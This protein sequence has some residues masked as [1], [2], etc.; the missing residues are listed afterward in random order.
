MKIL[1]SII[2][3]LL[4]SFNSQA[5]SDQARLLENAKSYIQS[6]RYGE[7]IELLNRF[8]AANPQSYEG[9][10]LR[11]ICHE[12]RGNYEQAVYDYRT[13]I[14]ISP[15]NKE[16]SENLA[17]AEGDWHRLLYNLIEGYKRE[18][19]INPSDPK[20]YLE[21]GKCYKNLGEW[22]EA[23][24]W[25]DLYLEKEEASSD[26]MLRYTEILA[27]NNHIL[28]GESYLKNYV[29]KYPDD[30]RL[31]SRYGYFLYWLGKTR[32][33][34]TAF[35]QA[36]KLRPFFKEALDGLDLLKGKKGL[37]TINDTNYFPEKGKKEKVYLIDKYLKLL[38]KNPDKDELRFNLINEFMKYNRIEEAYQQ[39][40]ILKPKYENQQRF[41][42]LYS[43]ILDKRN[44][45]IEREITALKSSVK[46]NPDDKK[47]L[48]K[49]AEL[50]SYRDHLSEAISLLKNYLLLNDD[51]EVQFLLAK[52]YMWNSDLCQSKEQLEYLEQKKYPDPQVA[53]LLA[54]IYL[55]LGI[56][57]Q[58]S[59]FLFEK[60][61]NENPDN[62][63]AIRGLIEAEL[64]LEK[65]KEAEKILSEN[66]HLFSTSEVLQIKTRIGELEGKKKLSDEYKILE[67]ARLLAGNKNYQLAIRR[68][69][70]FIN[71]QSQ[72]IQAK[73]ELADIYAAVLQFEKANE[74]LTEILN[75][76]YDLNFDKR[77]AKNIFWSKDYKTAIK[78]FKRLS[79]KFPDDVEIKIFLADSYLFNGDSDKAR[80]IYYSLLNQ[81]PESY[82][83]NQ[84]LVWLG[85][86]PPSEGFNYSVQLIPSANH[87]SDN[88]NI[89]YSGQSFLFRTAFTKNFAV[90]GAIH[91]GGLSSLSEE[92]TLYMVKGMLYL[93]LTDLMKTEA[94]FGQLFFNTK[95]KQFFGE[96]ILTISKLKN[97]SLNVSYKRS[98]A[99]IE[100]YSPSLVKK[101][102]YLNSSKINFLFN[103]G[104]NF[105]I[106]STYQLIFPE[107][108][109][110]GH[111]FS[112]K[113]GNNFVRNFSAG[114]EF[115]YL[116]FKE[117]S[118]LYWSPGNFISHS[119][120]SEW[121]ILK[122]SD[123]NLKCGGKIGLIPE[124]KFIL[125]EA[126][127]DFNYS[128]SHN[129]SFNAYVS[130]GKTYRKEA[131]GYTSF[132][133]I[134]S[135]TFSL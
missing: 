87:F 103:P 28:K 10:N 33:A 85:D 78:E 82:I 105:I 111:Q 34:E 92:R 126:F 131:G 5:Q 119:L 109:N 65:F 36:L 101:R 83:L 115:Y 107:D 19:A 125:S 106:S 14:K 4:L 48:M 68:Y 29:G 7:A 129:L 70:D 114:Y 93:S 104:F 9:F 79:L 56:E 57:I 116:N 88:Q 96:L 15:N 102:M 74:I 62:R 98:D 40:E 117:Q 3:F 58:K 23:E 45:I 31:W 61:L 25:Y 84:R 112:A 16:V 128:L 2:L 8:V 46:N 94:S 130:G 49:L 39:I 13:A 32:L 76:S 80:P 121:Q 73:S 20:N 43:K 44:E 38:N 35:E 77:R 67:E 91:R 134:S 59:E 89:T 110:E 63:D 21:I 118:D 11:G 26:E 124:N 53:L 97:F 60:Y 12:K 24:I 120:W 71:L 55:W 123:A 50:L 100:L 52:Y 17:R 135:L 64:I 95:E 47:S 86:N 54:K 30:H 41:Q 132:S 37:Y 27:K 6:E 113:I 122:L 133:L 22:N 72:N 69:L 75:K 99:S 127:M 66:E 81:A 42:E 1:L 51:N 108:S 90:G 18:I